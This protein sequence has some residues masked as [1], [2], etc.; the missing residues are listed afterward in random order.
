MPETRILAFEA[1]WS[2]ILIF[3]FVEKSQT[4]HTLVYFLVLF[5]RKSC[6]VMKFTV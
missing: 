3:F 6:T 1:F 4:W 5:C 2:L